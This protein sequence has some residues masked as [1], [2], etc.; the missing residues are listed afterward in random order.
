MLEGKKYALQDGGQY[1]SY[2]FVEK[3]KCH[4]IYYISL[5]C[6]SFPISGVRY[7]DIEVNS[8]LNKVIALI[9]YYAQNAPF[10]CIYNEDTTQI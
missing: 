7:D 9:R 4:K 10:V 1:K 3:S 6:V 8:V 2:Y 5:K